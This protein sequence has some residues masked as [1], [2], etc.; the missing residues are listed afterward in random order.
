MPTVI[1]REANLNIE[2]ERGT[3][4]MSENDDPEVGKENSGPRHYAAIVAAG[5]T[6]LLQIVGGGVC[7]DRGYVDAQV[8]LKPH[9][10]HEHGIRLHDTLDLTSRD[11]RTTM[12]EN[13]RMVYRGRIDDRYVD[14]GQTRVAA[15]SHDLQDAVEAALAGRSVSPSRTTA[16]GCFIIDL[17][18]ADD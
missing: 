12:S 14:F 2:T 5:E 1:V 18:R 8:V 4:P 15:T 10:T 11:W 9:R 7:C 6:I 16:I 17:P 13:R 3:K